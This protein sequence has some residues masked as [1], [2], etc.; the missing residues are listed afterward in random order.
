MDGW[1]GVRNGGKIKVVADATRYFLLSVQLPYF[2]SR[3]FYRNIVIKALFQI[4]GLPNK[5]PTK[6]QHTMTALCYC[7]YF[8]ATAR[9]RPLKS[10]A[11]KQ[12][13]VCSIFLMQHLSIKRKCICHILQKQISE[14]KQ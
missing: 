12:Y 7:Q 8:I 14:I 4:S 9:Y 3:N 5:Y 10:R 13:L 6:K 11:F 2:V 1:V